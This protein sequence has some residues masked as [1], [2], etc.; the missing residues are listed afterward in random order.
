MNPVNVLR[1]A[2]SMSGTLKR[3]VLVGCEP[4]SFG[5]DEG[6]MGFSNEVEAAIEPAVE[7]VESLVKKILGGEPLGSASTSQA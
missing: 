6:C 2:R 3:V 1:L 7:L 4:A 5:E